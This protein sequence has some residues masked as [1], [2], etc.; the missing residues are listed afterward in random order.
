MPAIGLMAL[1]APYTSARAQQVIKVM[2]AGD[3]ITA[4]VKGQCSYRQ[5]LV[6]SFINANAG[7]AGR[8]LIDMVGQFNATAQACPGNFTSDHQGTPGVSAAQ[9]LGNSSTNLRTRVDIE[10]PDVLLLHIGTNDVFN[11]DSVSKI[12]NDITALITGINEEQASEGRSIDIHLADVIPYDPVDRPSYTFVP[13]DAPNVDEAARSAELS[14]ALVAVADSF[15]NV[16]LVEVREGFDNPTMAIDGVHPNN[17]GEAHVAGRFLQSM[18]LAGYCEP[19]IT[20]PANLTSLS[21][22]SQSFT[23]A[24]QLGSVDNWWFFAGNAPGDNSYYNSGLLNSSVGGVTATGLPTAGQSVFTT[25]WYQKHG[26]STWQSVSN[27]YVA[28]NITL[29]SVQTPVPGSTLQ[30]SSVNLTWTANGATMAE[31]WVYAGSSVGSDSHYNSGSLPGGSVSNTLTNLPTD[32]STVYVTLWY[33]FSA[34]G[35]WDRL[36][37]QYTAEGSSGALGATTLLSP[38]GTGVGSA[39]ALQWERVPGA[40]WYRVWIDDEASG[41]KLAKWYTADSLGCATAGPCQIVPFTSYVGNTQWWVRT[42]RTQG[43]E[44]G[45]WSSSL[46]F[47]Q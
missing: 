28:G 21:G 26:D 22:A 5:N 38:S 16:R 37:L 39:P 1:L 44:F 12:V 45:P 19:S 14:A 29:P 25:L 10:D 17:I 24:D 42:Y 2:P 3:S 20:F 13:N 23:W 35:P 11:G 41:I 36:N 9:M 4:G 32:G 15:S 34:S 18:E 31:W 40:T 27:E 47:S 33:R 7:G 43:N 8:C 46:T 6:S 30:S